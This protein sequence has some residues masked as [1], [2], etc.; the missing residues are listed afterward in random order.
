[1]KITDDQ[2]TKLAAIREEGNKKMEEAM[3]ALRGGGGG[4]DAGDIREK[5]M[6]CAKNW[7]TR[8]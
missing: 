5:M 1:M 2:K 4:G 3:A 7:A 8:P 6:E